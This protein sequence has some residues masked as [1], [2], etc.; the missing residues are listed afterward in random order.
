MVSTMDQVIYEKGGTDSPT[1][2]TTGAGG[3]GGHGTSIQKHFVKDD[4]LV[5]ADLSSMV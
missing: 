2:F 1:V 5:P 4:G 3:G